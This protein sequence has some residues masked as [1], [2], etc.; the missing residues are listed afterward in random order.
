MFINKKKLLGNYIHWITLSLFILEF[1][2]ES[3]IISSACTQKNLTVSIRNIVSTGQ[4]LVC[5]AVV[6]KLKT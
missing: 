6:T 1:T 4:C 3:N 5:R 2:N